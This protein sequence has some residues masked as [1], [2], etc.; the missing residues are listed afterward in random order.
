MWQ[1]GA[2][3]HR[4][5]R[6]PHLIGIAFF[7]L[8]LYV[9]G[10]EAFTFISGVRPNT[11][12]GGIGWLAAT[13]IAMPPLA[14]GKGMTGRQLGNPVLRTESHATLIDAVLVAAVLVGLVLNALLG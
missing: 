6:A 9:L 5:E 12:V 8:A 11:S 3:K 7:L 4:E 13:L 2:D 14:W 10:R 1:L